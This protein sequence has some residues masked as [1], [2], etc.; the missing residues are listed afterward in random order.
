MTTEREM[1]CLFAYT[2]AAH[3]PDG[4]PVLMFLMPEAAWAYMRDGLCHEFDLTNV[5]VPIQVVIGR[6]RDHAHGKA[7]L[8]AAGAMDKTAQDTSEADLDM[9]LGGKKTRQ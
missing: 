6:C 4:V 8:R 7:M 2:S 9:H 3:A 1:K 5:G